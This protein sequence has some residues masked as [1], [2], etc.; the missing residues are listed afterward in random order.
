M[1]LYTTLKKILSNEVL[2]IVESS[3][4]R[5]A[6]KLLLMIKKLV[7]DFEVFQELFLKHFFSE[8]RQW[9]IFIKCTEAGERPI[10]QGF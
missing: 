6:A 9:D 2:L 8:G 4:K 10:Q 3:L 7:T 1:K 5:R